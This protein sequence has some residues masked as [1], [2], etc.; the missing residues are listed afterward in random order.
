MAV[1][2]LRGARDRLVGRWMS[3]N[4]L[5]PAPTWF[6]WSDA[7]REKW[8]LVVAG[9]LVVVAAV[10]AGPLYAYWEQAVPWRDRQSTPFGL[11]LRQRGV[12]ER[13]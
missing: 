9:A 5:V 6:S 13:R 3:A 2:A 12:E 4:H 1:T 8:K 10:A 11:G 7:E